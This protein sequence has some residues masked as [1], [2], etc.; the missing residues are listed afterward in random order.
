MNT[1]IELPCGVV[2]GIG[3][4]KVFASDYFSHEIP[5]LS[6]TVAKDDSGCFTATCIQLVLEGDGRT[7][8]AAISNMRNT[9][10]D[11]LTRLF[12]TEKTKDSA[13]AQ[14]HE[15]YN[16]SI[17]GDYWKA[18]RDMQLNL[19]EQGISTDTKQIYIDEI[20][21]LKKRIVEL[22]GIIASDSKKSFTVK[23]V[24]YQESAA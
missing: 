15:L 9:V 16:D 4:L 20:T 13:W 12:S 17:S 7:P 21:E 2:V 3:K 8:D 19:A 5:T 14:L 23:I 10:L 22:E 24:D 6:F 18:Y 1:S 11:F